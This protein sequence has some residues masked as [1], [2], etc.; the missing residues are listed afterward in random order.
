MVNQPRPL[1]QRQR[2]FYQ[3]HSRI[4]EYG[5][6][7]SIG[8]SSGARFSFSAFKIPSQNFSYRFRRQAIEAITISSFGW[9]VVISLVSGVICSL[10]IPDINV[11]GKVQACITGLTS[12]GAWALSLIEGLVRE[13]VTSLR[14]LIKLVFDSLSSLTGLLKI[15]LI[16]LARWL[17]WLGTQMFSSDPPGAS[18]VRLQV[19][20]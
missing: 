6:S 15:P 3:L 20:S 9:L 8:T 5:H 18:H 13:S 4:K 16:Q 19:A 2:S 7:S 12:S 10:L 11:K 1:G 17:S 14:M